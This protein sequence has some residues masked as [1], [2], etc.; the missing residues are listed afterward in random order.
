MKAHKFRMK[1]KLYEAIDV[2]RRISEEQLVRYRCFRILPDNKF[3]VQSADHY[4]LPFDEQA[5]RQH[6][7][8][9]FELLFEESPDVREK[10][11]ATSEEAIEA[12]ERDFED[13]GK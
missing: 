8:R 2:W 12:F 3:C 11:Y 7:K 10:T 4:H 6:D 9:F 5:N 13:I 1:N